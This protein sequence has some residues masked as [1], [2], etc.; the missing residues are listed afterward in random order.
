MTMAMRRKIEWANGRI[1]E[2]AIRMAGRFCVFLLASHFSL[3]ASLAFA[4]DA[5]KPAATQPTTQGTLEQQFAERLT[6]VVMVGQFTMG[7]NQAPKADKYTI[8]SV[9]KMAGDVWLFN[10]KVQYRGSD[11]VLPL[12]VPVKWAGDTA[13]ISVTDFG[14]PG[15]GTY[16]A[17]VVIYKD[18]YAGIWMAN[19]ANGRPAHGG[20]MW[21]RIERAPATQ[22]AAGA[23]TKPASAGAAK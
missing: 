16:T 5:S 4:Q 1:G 17:R 12:P 3:L 6:N 21:G 15:M 13:V 2:P 19:A 8:V 7:D 20:Q 11:V 22:P 9:R 23:T 10:A 18:Q 14:L